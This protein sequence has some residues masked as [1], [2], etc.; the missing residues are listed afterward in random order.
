MTKTEFALVLLLPLL[1]AG[2][3]LGQTSTNFKL[4]EHVFNSGGH[5][6]AGQVPTSTNF[7]I[8]ID[9]I[10]E[11]IIGQGLASTSF[12]ID[13]CFLSAYPPPGEVLNLRFPTDTQTLVWDP[14]KSVGTYSLYR[15]LVSNLS[16]TELGLCEQQAIADE[17]TIDA[18]T[19][20]SGDSY[21]YGVTAENKLGEEGTQGFDDS[22]TERTNDPLNACP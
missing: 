2:T 4:E 19:P 21:F 13:A 16:S 22:G 14:E 18:S 11:G 20:P 5:P 9:S 17:T 8:S 6:T 1:I 15:D 12:D 10:G 7:K 3:A